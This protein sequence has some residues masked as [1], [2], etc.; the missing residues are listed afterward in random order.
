MTIDFKEKDFY[1]SCGYKIEENR[2]RFMKDT[3][4][5]ICNTSYGQV[6][7][8]RYSPQEKYNN[9]N[10][11]LFWLT[12]VITL[13]FCALTTS[14]FASEISSDIA[15][16]TA[17]QNL[18]AQGDG[19]YKDE[20]RKEAINLYKQALNIF[21][22]V[23]A[24]YQA[25]VARHKL[26][27]S[28][29]GLGEHQL[30]IPLF[31]ANILFHRQ[32]RDD[33]STASYL[34]YAAQSYKQTANIPKAMEYLD[35]AMDRRIRDDSKKAEIIALQSSLLE[36]E[37]RIN[38]ALTLLA[39]GYDTLPISVWQ[40]NLENEFNRLSE[41]VEYP[42]RL[43]DNSDTPYLLWVGLGL[44]LLAL[45]AIASK[46]LLHRRM[47]ELILT[48]SS[49]LISLLVA[50]VFLRLMYPEPPHIKYLL[51]HP[52]QKTVFH[53]LANI[54]PGVN[55]KETEF[56]TN[57]IGLRGDPLPS[58]KTFRILAVGGSSTEA[59]FLDDPDAWPLR[60]QQRLSKL[61]DHNIWVGNAGKSG[62]N[63]FSHVS[64]IYQ[65]GREIEPDLILITAGINDL[66]QCISGGRSAIRDNHRSFKDPTYV[67]K[68]SQHV[69]SVIKTNT[70]QNK[71]SLRL[72]E[73]ANRL[74]ANLSEEAT[75]EIQ[76]DYVIQDDAGLFYH[77]QRKRR[78]DAEKVTALPDIAECLD[79]FEA[80]LN[81]MVLLGDELNIPLVFI[82][83]GSL[84][85]DS[86]EQHELDLLWFGSV[87]ENPFSVDPPKRYYTAS[88]MQALLKQYNDR[89]LK[90]CQEQELNCWDTDRYL[91]KTT[92][93]YYDDVHL[94]ISGS[95]A[96]GDKLADFIISDVIDKK[97]F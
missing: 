40:D 57:N 59:L 83:Q 75:T 21:E 34:L 8:N 45:M 56:T 2:L 3:C 11:Q 60:M 39:H 22:Q 31:E 18:M 37:G 67:T 53:P 90:V 48:V 61:S 76:F 58:G 85:R 73:L 64:Q 50:E 29:V 12:V 66:N 71:E 16:R 86:L 14:V 70:N 78:Q 24:T 5:G 77:E 93:T 96:L 42:P 84:Y 38:D 1:S 47:P 54:M 92:A 17:G 46:T 74:W 89:T 43:N 49:L 36:S 41:M 88:V 95:H 55:Y 26:A 25:A 87:D 7:E 63:S 15:M 52:N 82:T 28:Y 33:D 97:S 4:S 80:N 10:I 35:E 44:L 20:N 62:L 65:S 30:A 81:H 72:T 94:N 19:L 9:E 91:P 69:F 32:R 13:L 23:D 51:H 6:I 79:A 68:Y 27:F